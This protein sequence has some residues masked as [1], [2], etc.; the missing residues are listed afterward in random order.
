M[1]WLPGRF[2]VLASKQ[3]TAEMLEIGLDRHLAL[4]NQWFSFAFTHHSHR[5]SLST[6]APWQRL[7]SQGVTK[8]DAFHRS[9]FLEP[10]L[11][12]WKKSNCWQFISRHIYHWLFGTCKGHHFFPHCQVLHGWFLI[13]VSLSMVPVYRV[14]FLPFSWLR[15]ACMGIIITWVLNIILFCFFFDLSSKYA[16]CRSSISRRWSWPAA[17]YLFRK[18]IDS[19]LPCPSAAG[20]FIC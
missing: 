14:L 11:P 15:P 13:W 6:H 5:R 3:L 9:S 4:R 1:C 8:G 7:Q 10:F 20:V 17:F 2:T 12:P 18:E 19:L 16:S